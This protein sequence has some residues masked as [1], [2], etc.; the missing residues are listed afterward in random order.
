MSI[1]ILSD[2]FDNLEENKLPMI[3]HLVKDYAQGRCLSAFHKQKYSTLMRFL[4]L[5]VTLMAVI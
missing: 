4:I 1:V 3:G 5:F 2:A